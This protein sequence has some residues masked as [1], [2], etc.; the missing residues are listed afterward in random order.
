[1]AQPYVS[2]SQRRDFSLFEIAEF[3]END[4]LMFLAEQSSAGKVE[5]NKS[6]LRAV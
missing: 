6:V 3:S 4:A 1:M 2:S 5:I